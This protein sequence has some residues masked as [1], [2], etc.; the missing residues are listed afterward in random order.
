[1]CSLKEVSTND[2]L[3]PQ[4][5][6][7]SD[8]SKDNCWLFKFRTLNSALYRVEVEKRTWMCEY[9]EKLDKISMKYGSGPPVI[10]GDLNQVVVVVK[11][12]GC[13]VVIGS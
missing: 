12:R 9:K 11:S 1:M 10:D 2:L 8:E 13:A 6:G 4:N 7:S 3:A 5:C